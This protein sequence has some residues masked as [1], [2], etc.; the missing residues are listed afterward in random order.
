MS[1]P[2]TAQRHLVGWLLVVSSV[3]LVVDELRVFSPYAA[4]LIAPRGYQEWVAF[5]HPNVFLGWAEETVFA[6][7][8]ALLAVWFVKRPLERIPFL[9]AVF[10]LL[11]HAVAGVVFHTGEVADIVAV[12]VYCVGALAYLGS[13]IV[14]LRGRIVSGLAE[15]FVLLSFLVLV[16]GDLAFLLIAIYSSAAG[17]PFGEVGAPGTAAGFFGQLLVNWL[18]V[19]LSI[20]AGIGQAGAGIALIRWRPAAFA[21]A[22]TIDSQ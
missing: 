3:F 19:G 2:G 20:L 6:A 9:V 7:A 18:F 12:A 14:M 17:F 15:A 11:L 1:V 13:G 4:Y 16:L 8:L 10:G 22:S 5:V 21:Q